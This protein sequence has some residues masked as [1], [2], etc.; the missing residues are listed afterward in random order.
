MLRVA[1]KKS[2]NKPRRV[3]YRGLIADA[4]MLGVHRNH[5]YLVLSGKRQSISLLRRYRALKRGN[6]KN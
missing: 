2:E 6:P 1:T 3:K 4:T 5:L